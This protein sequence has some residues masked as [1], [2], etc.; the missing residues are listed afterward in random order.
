MNHQSAEHFKALHQGEQPLVLVNIWDAAGAALLQEQGAQALATSSASLAWS[1]G[2]ADGDTLPVAE[3]LAAVG[4]I[5]RVCRVPLS[6]DIEQGYSDN[7]VEVAALAKQLAELGVAGIN[8]ED[9]SGSAELLVAKIGAIRFAVGSGLFIN[10]RTDV[11][12]RNLA[13]GE[14]A[15]DESRQR[16]LAYQ[17]AGAD[18]GFIP[19][20]EDEDV[21]AQLAEAVSMPLN[22]M[23][24]AD[25]KTI[26]TLSACGIRRFSMGPAPFLVAYGAVLGWAGFDEAFAALDYGQVNALFD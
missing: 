26:S 4:R 15:V 5:T 7:P 2:Y 11:Y 23:L 13:Q 14:A 3:L 22:L 21:A 19:G 24:S 18:G 1:L 10:A 16:L 20:L 9:G 8:L 17:Q 25:A 6:V 12:L